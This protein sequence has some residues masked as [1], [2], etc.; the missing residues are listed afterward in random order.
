MY[1]EEIEQ[2]YAAAEQAVAV[3]ADLPVHRMSATELLDARAR[4]ERLT[5]LLAAADRE[6]LARLAERGTDDF[7]G[8][9]LK[10]ILADRL[11]IRP[12]EAGHRLTEAAELASRILPSGECVPPILSHVAAAERRG[13]I[14]AGHVR[15]IREFLHHLPAA[16]D[17]PER[18]RAERKLVEFA[19]YLRPDE[20]EGCAKKMAVLLNPDGEFS[21]QDRARKRHFTMKPQGIDKMHSGTFCVDPELAAY[22]EAIFAKRAAPGMCH[23][24]DAQPVVE[25]VPD[26]DA[27]ARDGRTPG[28]RR[29]DALTSICRDALASGE[30][31]SHRGL[32]VTVIA[33]ATVQDL[34]DAAGIATTGG[35]SLLPMRDLIR[36]ASDALP[37]LCVFDDHSSTP[38]YF[39]RAKRLATPG[40]RLALHATDRGCSYPGCPTPGYICETH[41][42]NEWADGGA[43]DITN[44]T[45]ACP[46]HH[47]LVGTNP[48]RWRT[49]KN[50][51]GRTQWTPPHHVDPTGAPRVSHYHHAE[52]RLAG[53]T[54]PD[55][56]QPP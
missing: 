47:R 25:G 20:L 55:A 33:T 7:G 4:H 9:A 24:D 42:L 54:G 21:D 37:Y 46:A 45:F 52:A 51:T 5:R 19:E 31:G 6:P 32:P 40:Q 23:P 10:A 44:L 48:T 26:R 53:S 12:I 13:A 1:T 49:S 8:G 17:A 38:L 15:V 29:H 2:A 56:A 27:A 35:G 14:G 16:V 3:L 22:L 28:Q 43:T 36:M 11:L 50:P 41:H 34:Q 30:L 18:D 39:G